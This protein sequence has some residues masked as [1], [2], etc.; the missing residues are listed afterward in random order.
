MRKRQVVDT[1]YII[2]LLDDDI[3]IIEDIREESV[4]FDIELQN[5]LC[6]DEFYVIDEEKWC[7]SNDDTRS[8]D[9]HNLPKKIYA[10]ENNLQEKII[11]TEYEKRKKN[12]VTHVNRED[13]FVL[14]GYPDNSE[15]EKHE[16]YV[17]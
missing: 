1:S 8:S 12:I 17:L 14:E 15:N 9:E 10:I 7:V 11:D 5:T 13:I 3:T 6:I 4:S 16:K 2:A